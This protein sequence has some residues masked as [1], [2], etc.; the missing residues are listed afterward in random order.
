MLY[1]KIIRDI[2]QSRGTYMACI[3][4]MTIGLL[5]YNVFGITY[6]G[7]ESSVTSFYEVQRFG[8]GFAEVVS[9][10]YEKVKKLKNIK[11]VSAV[12]GRLVHQVKILN[13]DRD[14]EGYLKLVSYD[15]KDKEQLNRFELLTGYPPDEKVTSLLLDAKYF[16]G[17]NRQVG[18][19]LEILVK[20]QLVDV[21]ITGSSRSPEFIYALKSD[22]DLYPD[23]EHF[24]IAYMPYETMQKLF[25]SSNVINDLS[26]SFN[27]SVDFRNIKFELE[28]QLD[29]YGLI[30]LYE[31]KDQQSHVLLRSEVNGLKELS[32]SLP[33][34]FLGIA[35][36]IL[37][38]MLKRLIEKQRGQIAVLKAFGLKDREVLQHYI[39]Y[40]LVIGVT[41]GL[42]GGLLGNLLV[43][44]LIEVYKGFFNM[45]LDGG[46]F[47]YLFFFKG[48]GMAVTTAII[49]GYLGA[50]STLALEPAE[51]LRPAAPKSMN[52]IALERIHFI[53]SRLSMM[54][55]IA[56]RNIFRNKGRSSFLL[57]GSIFTMGILGMPYALGNNLNSMIFNQ[58]EEVMLYDLKMTFEEPLN[59]NPVLNRLKQEDH[60]YRVE[61]FVEVPAELSFNGQLKRTMIIGLTDQGQLYK[62]KNN[63]NQ[64]VAVAD[65]GIILSERLAKMLLVSSGD[66]VQLKSP[67]NRL[68]DKDINVMV[69]AVI[70]QYLGINAYMNEDALM[71]LL[72]QPAFVTSALVKMPEVEI[73][74]IK[75]AYESASKVADVTSK[76]ELIDKYK[77]LTGMMTSI[78]GIML[79]VGMISGFSIIY[80][81][82]TITISERQRELASML[83]IGMTYR[84]VASVIF[85]E[86]W[87]IAALGSVLSLPLIKSLI[88]IM[89]DALGNDVY[90]FPTE[91][92][93]Q[94]VVLALI[95]TTLSIAT[96]QMSMRKQINDLKLVEALSIRE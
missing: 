33:M 92:T 86:Q 17:T 62:L 59:R 91:M 78:L 58:F 35:S 36:A 3:V 38:I 79:F 64:E 40:A 32:S 61:P 46:G 66:T 71:K 72:N 19:K 75:D 87:Y 63:L 52:K 74:S 94:T 29:S 67:Y 39:A 13:E 45:P 70:P 37:I 48:M 54:N 65:D 23:P 80:A 51:A 55:R 96:A 76:K 77:S 27:E 73:N 41:S 30:K 89:S 60:I 50:K 22:Q 4:I 11:G 95:L 10:P 15:S 2:W 16:N 81:S 31:R 44:P 82:S 6:D 20:G 26:F 49:A 56:I 12:T 25:G 85:L 88:V 93:I 24:G 1:K 28:D 8:D 21:T 42:L 5:T 7:I 9:M 34:V 84:E 68:E 47:S 90:N 83:V 53:W 69:S 57:I 43:D 18:E 14:I